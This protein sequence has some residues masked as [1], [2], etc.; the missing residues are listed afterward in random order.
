MDRRILII[1]YVVAVIFCVRLLFA[2]TGITG[3]VN[4]HLPNLPALGYIWPVLLHTVYGAFLF[5]VVIA[6]GGTLLTLLRQFV[7]LSVDDINILGFP[8]GLFSC[9]G[10]SLLC[11]LGI[12]GRLVA[13][14]AVA[15][16]LGYYYRCTRIWPLISKLR[17][18]FIT[19]LAFAFGAHLAFIWKPT[20]AVYTGAIG[21]GDV[22]TYAGLYHSL[23]VSLFPFYN[24]GAEGDVFSYFNN[25]HTF[26]ALALD[27]FPGFDIY[28]FIQASLGTFYILS[29]AYMLNALVLY[30]SHL[31]Y[32]ALSGKDTVL[33]TAVLIAAARYPSW[34]VDSPPA[35]FMAPL[36]M[37]VLYAVTRAGD[38]PLRLG[39][40]LALA[41]A[42][43]VISKVVSLVVLGAYTGLKL[44]YFIIRRASHVHFVWLAVFTC[45]IAYYVFYM[46]QN[47][48]N[49]LSHE[50]ILGPESW[51]RFINK[52][53]GEFH[54]VL[55]T[56]LKDIGLVLIV[57]GTFKLKDRPL[58]FAS[59]LAVALNFLFSFLFTS[60]P[61]AM[62]VLIAGYLITKK[63]T[64][65]TALRFILIG[66]LLILP[67]YLKHDPGEWHMTL[68]W[69][70]A[71]GPAAVLA[72]QYTASVPRSHSKQ[73]GI[74][75]GWIHLVSVLAV[76]SLSLVALANGDLRLGKKNLQV[77]PLTL[78]DIW[79]KTRQLTPEA[80]LI[81]TDQTG[82]NTERLSGWNDYSLM[83]Q[84]QFYISSWSVSRLR[85]QH[86]SRR[87]RLAN[88][89]AVLAGKLSPTALQLFRHYTDYY[90]VV[91][92]D[93][94]V[95]KGFGK[96]YDNTDYVLYEIRPDVQLNMDS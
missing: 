78:Y 81:F 14:I 22:T 47:F 55:P 30:R 43:S 66:A 45:V 65:K 69:I 18:G 5:C 21:L 60:T 80:S 72:L 71:L 28:L 17:L 40:A 11:C 34:I 32:E 25:L 38:Y 20:T 16:T 3:A 68:L 8:A 75:P 76:A 82:D 7:K 41:V 23:K 87:E 50:W 91:R 6:T 56:L 70:L 89:E 2:M 74:A 31:G 94:P 36:T 77:V 24:L 58:F 96:V 64:P 27:I 61:T 10:L 59:L 12:T 9:L 13:A 4:S 92:K 49:L 79:A 62:L 33:I 42:A 88:N 83:A 15:G 52:G 37:S 29:V 85:R 67:Y 73:P 1:F 26:Y 90:A 93:T 86:L 39:F 57:A 19:I 46:V 95:P 51:Q 63:E 84:R 44:L 53:W 54:K 48:G 35:V